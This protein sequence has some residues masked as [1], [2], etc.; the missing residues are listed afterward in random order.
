[1]QILQIGTGKV[2]WEGANLAGANLAGANLAGAYLARANLRGAYLRGAY[3][4]GANLAGAYLAR[5]N[6]RGADLRGAYLTG[7]DLAGADLTGANL[8]G[9][10][11]GDQWIIQGPV[12][13]DGYYF[14]LTNLTYEGP[15]IKAGCRNFTMQ[16]ARQHW[17]ETRAN[18]SLGDETM[19][20][21]DCLEKIAK[22]RGLI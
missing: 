7:A 6:L 19:A 16:K 13:S 22:I 12:R 1:M 17:Q 20:I 5:A 18:T 9:A 8:A 11:L 3:L 4:A 2:L 10:N 15:R 14:M 21:L